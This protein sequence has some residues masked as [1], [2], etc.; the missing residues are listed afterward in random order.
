MK[1]SNSTISLG[2][3]LLMAS[4]RNDEMFLKFEN[5]TKG[6]EENFQNDLNTLLNSEMFQIVGG[7]DSTDPLPGDL[8]DVICVRMGAE[9]DKLNKDDI[10]ANRNWSTVLAMQIW[11]TTINEN[12]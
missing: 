3:G 9:Y 4:P 2:E 10:N 8:D 1:F 7:L 5:I 6:L 12:L 11:N